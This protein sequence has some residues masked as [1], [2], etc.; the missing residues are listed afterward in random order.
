MAEARMPETRDVWPRW[1]LGF[2]V[3]LVL[4]IGAVLALLGVVYDAQ[5]DWP[6][7]GIAS[8]SNEASP[9]LQRYPGT[10]LAAFRKRMLAELGERGWV[11]R[12][13]GM[14][15]IPIEDAMRIVA[16]QG[17][18]DWGQPAA[19]TDAAGECAMLLAAVPRSRQ[20]PRCRQ[21]GGT[22]QEPTK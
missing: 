7:P 5:P 21:P 11:D 20:A 8:R 17:L 19:A 16:E 10:D 6:A 1:L 2:A 18:P 14:A 12:S 3:A 15:R 13:A 4:F 9:A 22:Q